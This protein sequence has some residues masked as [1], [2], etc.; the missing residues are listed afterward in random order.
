MTMPGRF[1]MIGWAV[2]LAACTGLP[3]NA[4]PPRVSIADVE[5]KSLGL[6]EQKFDVGLR[7]ANPNDFDLKIEGLDFDLEV[8]GRPFASGLSRVSTLVPAASNTVLRVEAI[9]QSKNLARQIRTLPPESTKEGVP[10][11]VKGRVKTDKASNW[12]PF[13]HAGVYGGEPKKAPGKTI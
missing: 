2:L 4:V 11:R 9:V 1:L 13:D 3:L 5:V 8:N 6:F 7:V 10:Y 12:L